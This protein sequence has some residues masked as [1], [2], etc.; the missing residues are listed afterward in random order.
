V[1]CF[2]ASTPGQCGLP[3]AIPPDG[4]SPCAGTVRASLIG[5]LRN[6]LLLVGCLL[7][8][9]AAGSLPPAASEPAP[10]P[11]PAPQPGRPPVDVEM[12]NVDLHVTPDIVLHIRH[13]RGRFIG[14]NKSGI[15]FLDDKSS[16]MVAIDEAEIAMDMPSLNV[17]MNEH[18]LG[19][20]RSNIEKVHVS[21]EDGL[22]KQKG[23]LD[24]GIDIPFRVK[25]AVEATPDG[26]IRV[27]A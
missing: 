7:T 3:S 26:R 22:L 6:S 8:S 27:H 9:H 4:T 10:P 18:V 21:V 17:L 20:G 19:H 11:E 25:G 15:P 23:V 2:N 13:L 1:Q 16:Y 5:I 14:T 24:K 12:R